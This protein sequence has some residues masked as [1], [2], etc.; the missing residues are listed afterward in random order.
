MIATF[1]IGGAHPGGL[2][3]TKYLLSNVH[4]AEQ[5]PI[6]DVGCGT[7][8]T[9]AY[10]AKNFSNPLYGI[11][12]H[13]DM[14]VK[15]KKRLNNLSSITLLQATAESLPFDD[16][17]FSLILSESVTAFTNSEKTLREYFRLL[18]QNG[19]LILLE[20]TAN[21]LLPSEE[22]TEIEQFYQIPR[23]FTEQMWVTAIKQAG[24]KQ[25]YTE[26]LPDTLENVVDFDLHPM[27]DSTYFELIANHYHLTEKYQDTLS[28]R[29]YLCTP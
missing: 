3:T 8:Q 27:I 6:L 25:V 28:A 5:E 4:L 1:G 13:Q 19:Q 9:L 18:K 12:Q 26:A 11:D 16:Q 10:L 7:G 15:A 21:E 29:I 23:L 20:M 24:F 17:Y 22:R 2:S 14:L